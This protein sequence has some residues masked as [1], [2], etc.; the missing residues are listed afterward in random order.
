MK[1][2]PTAQAKTLSRIKNKWNDLWAL[3]KYSKMTGRVTKY[4]MIK[5]ELLKGFRILKAS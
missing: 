5:L 4:L 1:L 3:S 2:I